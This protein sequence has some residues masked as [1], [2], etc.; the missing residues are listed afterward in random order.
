MIDKRP[1]ERR[2]VFFQGQDDDEGTPQSDAIA[3]MEIACPSQ[4]ARASVL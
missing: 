1:V 3:W 4:I 2:G